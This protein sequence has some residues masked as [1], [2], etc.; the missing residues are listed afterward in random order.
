[1]GSPRISPFPSLFPPF[2]FLFPFSFSSF[3]FLSPSFSPSLLP[4]ERHP[5]RSP[6]P[7]PVPDRGSARPAP[8]ATVSPGRDPLHAPMTRR[9]LARAHPPRQAAVGALHRRLPART[10][11]AESRHSCG[12]RARAARRPAPA[13]PPC[14][15]RRLSAHAHAWPRHSPAAR[16]RSPLPRPRPLPPLTPH[17]AACRRRRVA[18]TRLAS[19]CR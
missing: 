18:S 12:L 9:G 19:A 8:R 11:R 16:P 5:G 3:L 14:A 7:L 10:C 6:L 13:L 1:M 17:S 2:L 4:S 15:T